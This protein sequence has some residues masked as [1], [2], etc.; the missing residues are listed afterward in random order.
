MTVGYATL[1]S[2]SGTAGEDFI[3][4][5]G[6]LTF[7]AGETEKTVKVTILDDTLYEPHG[8]GNVF[9]QLSA[10]TGTA[11]LG[12]GKAGT[13][14]FMEHGD[15]DVPPTVTMESVT[16]DED[17]GTMEFTLS[18]SHGVEADGL[19]YF[20]ASSG[21]GGT[22][23]SGP[24][25]ESFLSGGS[26]TLAVPS[27]ATSATFSVSILDDDLDEDNE[28]ITMQWRHTDLYVAEDNLYVAEDSRSIDV[29]GTITDDDE[30]GVKVSSDSLTV[31]EGA[32]ATYTVVLT[33]KPTD[34]VT[35]TPSLATGSSS[36]VTFNPTSLSFGTTEW[37]TAQTVTVSAA[38]D[39]DAVADTATIEH[40]AAGGDYASAPTGEVSVTVTDDEQAS[41]TVALSVDVTS[42]DEDAGA[43]TIKVTGT[44]NGG[45]I[46]TA[47]DVEVSVGASGDGATEGTDYASVADL[48]LTI[49]AGETSGTATFSLTPTDDD[50]DEADETVSV[51]GT[52]TATGL[53]VTGTTTT[54]V[55]D[56]ERG[57][58]ISPTTLT[59]PEGDSA[60]YTVVLTSQPTATVTVTPSRSSGSADVTF[61]PAS[62]S[63]GT[64]D[65][66]T[67]KTVTVSAAQDD[68]AEADEAVLSHA[69]SG[70]DYAS[71]TAAGVDV[72]VGDDETASTAVA[73]S[74]SPASVDEDAGATS[75]TVTGTLDGAPR[76]ADTTV[77]VTVGATG[78]GA[79]E[80]TDYTSVAD[81]TLTVDAGENHGHGDVHADADGRRRG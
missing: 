67:A 6:T 40:A 4:T 5:S 63:F 24:D 20:V 44:L 56:D 30:R 29:T 53:T 46:A 45:T 18:L 74:V 15:N 27:R 12:R 59:V 72:T 51:T 47:T 13:L 80:G 79:T 16:V 42:V 77:T 35:V 61:S 10:L 70:G 78:D 9:V 19:Q 76:T 33:S 39:D 17:A 73:L 22:A 7:D 57:V 3:A 14:L 69:V 2:A 68:D 62:L 23:T 38:E 48:T 32:T 8:P 28:T 54:I 36:D 50:V 21:V 1:D 58:A 26:A 52:T 41:T 66:N 81:L 49:D 55:D 31:P 64:G 65:W 60:T 43:T 71:E 75:V 37:D 11:V 34:T 25:C